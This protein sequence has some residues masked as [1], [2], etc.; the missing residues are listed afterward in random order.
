[1]NS[2]DAKV[3]YEQHSPL[4]FEFKLNVNKTLNSIDMDMVHLISAKLQPW[5][6]GTEASPRVVMISGTGG[7][8]FCAG[9]DIVS[10]Y[11]LNKNGA[12]KD[13]KG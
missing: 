12:S 1:L 3:L 4:C 5:A 8:A 9:G 7:K 13:D 6:V 10:I 2:P 11:N